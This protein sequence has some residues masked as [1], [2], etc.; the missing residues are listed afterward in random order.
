MHLV[1]VLATFAV[2]VPALLL[3]TNVWRGYVLSVLWGWFVAPHF[4]LPAISIPIAIGISCMVGLLTMHRSGSEA[5]QEK[6]AGEKFAVALVVSL[7]APA[8]ALLIGWAAFQ[9]A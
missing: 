4:A 9:F 3:V 5:E 1:G 2:G 6:S 8:I 7:L